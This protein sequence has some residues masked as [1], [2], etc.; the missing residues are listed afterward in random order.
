MPVHVQTKPQQLVRYIVT[1][2]VTSCFAV[3]CMSD[4]FIARLQESVSPQACAAPDRPAPQSST[5]KGDPHQS[6]ACMLCVAVLHA[7]A[8]DIAPLKKSTGA[9]GDNGIAKM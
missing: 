5:A 6:E 1:N 2:R 8:V 7:C 4:S 3:C 9:G